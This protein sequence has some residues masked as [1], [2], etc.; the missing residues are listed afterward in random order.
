MSSTRR[1][2]SSI[3]LPSSHVPLRQSI[4]AYPTTFACGMYSTSISSSPSGAKS[5]TCKLEAA[6]QRQNL[7]HTSVPYHYTHVIMDADSSFNTRVVHYSPRLLSCPLEN[8]GKR[9]SPQVDVPEDGPQLP[10]FL[11]GKKQ[12]NYLQYT[13]DG[14]G[15]RD[16][17]RQLCG[18]KW[19]QLELDATALRKKRMQ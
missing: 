1:K 6:R 10:S 7:R 14:P 17:N 12:D 5:Y 3:L 11:Q 19:T 4:C 2:K 16:I 18:N 9:R 8:A 13:E 15:R